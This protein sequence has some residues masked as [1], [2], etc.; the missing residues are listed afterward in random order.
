M[1]CGSRGLGLPCVVHGTAG[2]PSST[3]PSAAVA[4][5]W[6]GGAH[7][8]CRH[9]GLAAAGPRCSLL[10]S[11][12]CS[13]SPR[14]PRT[15]HERRPGA[16]RS[17]RRPGRAPWAANV[18]QIPRR[19]TLPPGC[20]GST[21]GAGGLNF[22]VRNVTGCVPS[23]KATENL[24]R[25]ARRPTAIAVRDECGF[26]CLCGC[27]MRHD[28]CRASAS[29]TASPRPISTGRLHVLPRF[30]LRPINP[31]VWLGAL[32]DRVSGKP[33]LEASFVLRCLQR[34]SLP[35]VAN[36]QCPWQDNR[37]TRDPSTPVLS[38]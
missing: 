17:G 16:A 32:P 36:R 12:S 20:P 33:H 26:G 3:A 34:L 2:R 38:Y 13:A 31:V 29:A 7:A 9:A 22:R 18:R 37:H 8:P 28:N 4:V 25:R 15:N 14:D 19:P 11:C 27:Q 35:D 5:A 1:G 10:A 21:I 30:H 23:A 6:G 24:G